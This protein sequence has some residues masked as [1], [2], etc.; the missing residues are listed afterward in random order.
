[1]KYQK[2]ITHIKRTL[3]IFGRIGCGL[4]LL[5]ILASVALSI[6]EY[7]VAIFLMVFLFTL[8]FV[9][10]ATLPTWLPFDVR[11]LPAAAIWLSLFVIMVLRGGLQ[12]LSYQSRILLTERTQLRLRMVLG[13]MV[14][15]KEGPLQMPLSNIN[16]YFS[17]F[18]P[19][20]V[21]FIFHFSQIASF[22]VQA[23]M[24]SV[25]MFYFARGETLVGL[26][27]IGV[28]GIFVLWLNRYTHRTAKRVPQVAEDLERTKVRAVRNWLLIKILRTEHEEYKRYAEAVL[29][30]YRHR[31]LAYLIANSGTSL[32]PILGVMVIAV[33]VF[34]NAHFFQTPSVDLVA[35]LYLFFRFQQMMAH[36][37]SFI[38]DLFTCRVQ[39][40]E[41]IR[42]VSRVPSKELHS[43]F[44]PAKGLDL[45]SGRVDLSHIQPQPNH[46]SAA[47]PLSAAPINPPEIVIDNVTFTWPEAEAP[48]LKNLT[49]TIPNA[50]QIGITGPNGSGKSTLL[51]ILTGVLIPEFGSVTIDGVPGNDYLQ[52]YSG[53]VSYVG[54][55]PFL[56]QGS[57][58]QNLMYSCHHGCSD[59]EMMQALNLVRLRTFVESL[60]NGLD[61]GID[62]NGAGLSSGQKQR[63]AIARAFLRKPKL[64]VMDE[65]TTTIDK[66]AEALLASALRTFKG[67]C[68]VVIVSHK[69]EI[70]RDADCIFE[71]TPFEV[72]PS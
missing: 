1:M 69:P 64:L 12:M 72:T 51:A 16:L 53:W 49:L 55:E 39:F 36:G 14:F 67:I 31:S 17:E 34:A 10:F 4:F 58:R 47:S 57:V 59:E 20:A 32:I 71:M 70:L 5:N 18:F 43:A 28:M 11:N 61:Y 48:V 35:F 8:G 3:R 60:P 19:R 13:Y 21:S 68:T 15:M 56:I 24:I 65:P 38:G 2:N 46:S 30:Y 25:G 7:G 50:S 23:M 22:L 27:G 54:P 9:E 63:L 41:S 26:A 42:L 33:I 66:E 62:E 45:F 6:I 52:Q 29:Q 37:S 44:R 40:R